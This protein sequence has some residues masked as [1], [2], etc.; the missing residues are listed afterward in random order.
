MTYFEDVGD[1]HKKFDLPKFPDQE[2]SMLS[3]DLVKFRGAFM[4]E[5]LAEFF[6]AVGY[7]EVGHSLTTMGAALKNYKALPEGTNVHDAADALADLIYVACGT[8][9]FMGLPFDEIWNE[10]Q[11][12]NMTKERAS[13]ANDSRSKRRHASDVVKPANFV[14]PDHR[15]AIRRAAERHSREG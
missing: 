5:E 15:P 2:P 3:A 7:E 12:A 1:F 4:L 14:P 8:A 6:A 10:V 9:H 11:R 13:A